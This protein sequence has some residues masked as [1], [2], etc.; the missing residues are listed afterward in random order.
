MEFEQARDAVSEQEQR[1]DQHKEKIQ[2]LLEKADPFRVT[3]VMFL[4]FNS[5]K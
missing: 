1:S 5:R 2:S 3:V 4:L